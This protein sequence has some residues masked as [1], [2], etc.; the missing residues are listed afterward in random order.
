MIGVNPVRGEVTATIGDVEL[1]LVA[2]M[3]RLAALSRETG[4]PTFGEL[5]ARLAGGEPDTVIAALRN[6]TVKGRQ[7]DKALDY[8][9]AMAAIGPQL[10]IS[11]MLALGPKMTELLADLIRPTDKAKT[12]NP[13]GNA[14]SAQ[15]E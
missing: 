6:F 10:D 11:A 2:D 12:D 14:T 1:T 5:H 3:G 15:S 4:R 9:K 7:G 13:L 8:A